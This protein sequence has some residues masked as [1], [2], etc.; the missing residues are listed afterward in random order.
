MATDGWRSQTP[1][2]LQREI[3]GDSTIYRWGKRVR[4]LRYCEAK[5]IEGQGE[6]RGGQKFRIEL[7]PELQ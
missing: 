1:E 7:G 2:E 3:T 6:I 5:R 4:E